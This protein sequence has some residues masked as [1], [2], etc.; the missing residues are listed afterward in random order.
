MSADASSK[1]SVEDMGPIDYLIVEFPGKRSFGSGLP[2]FLDLV[3]RG[4]VRIL[5]LAII[6]KEP[7][8][9]V[10][11]PKLGDLSADL[12]VFEGVSSGLLDQHDIDNTAAVI[13]RDSAACLMVYENRW[14]APF[15]AAL[16]REGGQL[17]ATGRLSLEE[18]LAQ[19]DATE[20]A[21]SVG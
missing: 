4:I 9:T 15:A 21:T 20:L 2:I 7:D 18:V 6:R 14:A 3:D 1:G 12:A 11:R 19:L 5:D 8:G 16:R 13:E 10:S 17:V